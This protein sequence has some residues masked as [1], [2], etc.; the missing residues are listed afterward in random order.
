MSNEFM[1]RKEDEMLMDVL[2][3]TVSDLL[4]ELKDSDLGPLFDSM[5][6]QVVKDR[7][8]YMVFQ[9]AG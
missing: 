8:E 2:D 9:E 5:I 4:T 1:E 3:M 7:I 6:D